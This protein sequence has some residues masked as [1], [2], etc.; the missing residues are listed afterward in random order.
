MKEC[1]DEEGNVFYE[2]KGMWFKKTSKGLKPC[3]RPKKIKK[4]KYL[5]DK[6]RKEIEWAI[7]EEFK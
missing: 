6:K 5:G 3:E 2:I 1:V 4:V 7:P